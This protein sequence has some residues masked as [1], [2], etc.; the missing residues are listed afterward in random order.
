MHSDDMLSM[1]KVLPETNVFKDMLITFKLLGSNKNIQ[2]Q[3]QSR[4]ILKIM[5]TV[6]K[7][8]QFRHQSDMWVAD[9]EAEN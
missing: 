6:Q 2:I 1:S 9:P 3:T 4:E 8:K 7:E 5:H